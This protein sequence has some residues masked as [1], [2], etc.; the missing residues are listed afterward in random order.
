M[1]EYAAGLP[2]KKL[3]YSREFAKQRPY[4]I[5]LG[6]IALVP[7]PRE[8]RVGPVAKMKDVRL[9]SQALVADRVDVAV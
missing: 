5:A 8:N 9:E 2:T 3:F 7:I 6:Q 1:L 4:L